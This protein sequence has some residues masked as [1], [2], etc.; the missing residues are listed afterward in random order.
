MIKSASPGIILSVT[1]L[2]ALLIFLA[3]QDQR[4]GYAAAAM[5]V[6]PLP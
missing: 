6:S 1:M 2:A 3:I 4:H 5:D